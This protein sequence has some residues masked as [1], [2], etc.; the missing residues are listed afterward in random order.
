MA[1]NMRVLLL[2]LPLALTGCWSS[3]SRPAMKEVTR[4]QALGI[5]EPINLPPPGQ[6]ELRFL[7]V[8]NTL[9]PFEYDPREVVLTSGPETLAAFR[10]LPQHRPGTLPPDTTQ[11]TQPPVTLLPS[12]AH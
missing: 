6:T 8:G 10:A 9:V 1:T 11:L 7:V 12:L 5:V 2:A 4:E 3:T